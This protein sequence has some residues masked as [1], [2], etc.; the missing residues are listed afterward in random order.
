[1]PNPV[2]GSNNKKSAERDALSG[3]FSLP[4]FKQRFILYDYHIVCAIYSYLERKIGMGKEKI[5]VYGTGRIGACEATLT[6]GNGF[7]T[8]VV[9]HSKAGMERCRQTIEEN[10]EV[11]IGQGLATSQNKQAALKL[12]TI[13]DDCRLLDGCSFIFEAVLEKLEVKADVFAKIEANCAENTVIASCTSSFPVRVLEQVVKHKDRILIAHPFQP[14]HMLPLVEVV[15]GE[16][17]SDEA[18]AHTRSLLESL[19]RK[20]VVMKKDLPGFLVNRFAQ[21]LFRESIYLIEQGVVTAEEI[22]M[23]IKYAMG[24]RYA[25]IGLLEYFDDVGFQLEQEIAT[26]VYPDLCAATQPQQLVK[27]GI[28]AG[29]TGLA[30]GQGLYDWSKKDL[31]DYK[32]RKQAPYFKELDWDMPV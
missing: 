23:A 13:T 18:V 11:L 25:S 22:D 3:F 19:R 31:E 6:T 29:K 9:G 15:R 16:H 14:A 8:V 17:T 30:A 7:P 20:V 32:M 4:L 21:A 28:A 27:D 26:N 5:G 1:M 2:N 10:W 24:M 12:L